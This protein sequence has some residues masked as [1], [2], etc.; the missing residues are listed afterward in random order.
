MTANAGLK[1]FIRQNGNIKNW[2]VKKAAST[3]FQVLAA[4][5]FRA[6]SFTACQ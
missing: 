6:V 2:Q 5:P 3:R 4:L 1:R